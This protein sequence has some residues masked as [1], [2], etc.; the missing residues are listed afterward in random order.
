MSTKRVA[1][2]VTVTLD[3]EISP[4]KG[5]FTADLVVE[6]LEFFLENSTQELTDVILV[7]NASP[8]PEM[9]D[10]LI[11]SRVKPNRFI[12]LYENRGINNVFREVLP[13]LDEY[14]ILAF[15]HSDFMIIDKGW[16]ELVVIAF[17]SDP[18]LA[19]AGVAGSS[20]VDRIGGRGLGTRTSFVGGLYRSGKGSGVDVHGKRIIGV[21]PAAVLDH[22]FMIFRRSVLE[23]LANDSNTE[24]IFVPHHFG[25]KIFG[26]EILER[27]YHVALLGIP[28]DHLQGG[29]GI[30]LEQ[31][32]KACQQWL[33]ERNIPFKPD[34][35]DHYMYLES[36]RIFLSKWRDTLKFIP[37]RVNE[38]Y[39]ITH[40]HPDRT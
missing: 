33:E 2:V 9:V 20:E 18:K 32:N 17:D 24:E 38:D 28:C 21:N 31:H 39:S 23:E 8:K 19:L 15:A 30:G 40:L 22:C 12:R 35:T 11:L 36:E 16:D 3:E 26:C 25:D 29:R 10:N 6:C 4:S 5:P 27:G 7:D 14:D 37:L 13:L 1:A 34:E